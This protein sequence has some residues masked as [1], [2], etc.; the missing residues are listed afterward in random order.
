MQSRHSW[1][2][3]SGVQRPDTL[4]EAGGGGIRESSAVSSRVCGSHKPTKLSSHYVLNSTVNI[5]IRYSGSGVEPYSQQFNSASACSP[6]GC[7]A[8]IY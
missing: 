1:R 7:R 2:V 3:R 4:E 6:V 8:A 5:S